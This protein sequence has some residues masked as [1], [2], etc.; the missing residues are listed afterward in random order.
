[1]TPNPDAGRPG[2]EA[3]HAPED[4]GPESG[5]LRDA[6]PPPIDARVLADASPSDASVLAGLL[7]ELSSSNPE[8]GATNVPRTTWVTLGFSSDVTA[9]L[10]TLPELSCDD[11]DTAIDVSVLDAR[12]LVVDPRGV[13]PESA[14]CVV[15]LPTVRGE[16]VVSF[17]VAATG[18]PAEVPYDRNDH[19]LLGPFPDSFY[20][21][22]DASTRTG[23]RVEVRTPD[24]DADVLQLIDAAIAPTTKLD[25]MSPIAP[26]VV[27][28]PA[29][30]DPTTIPR[31]AAES[32]SPLATL[33][34]FDVDPASP[35]HGKRVPF[36][37]L[38]RDEADRSGDPAHV[39]VVF[40]SV[41]LE[42]RGRYAFAVTNRVLVDPSRPLE[43]SSFF[44]V[45]SS[46]AAATA[47]ELRTAPGL[48]R[49]TA[50]LERTTPPLRVDDLAL[51]LAVDVRSDDD[52]P[53]DLLAI[54]Q[55]VLAAPPPAF[56]I[57]QVVA[58][59]AAGSDVAAV[60][61]GTWSPLNFTSDQ[62][63][64]AR[65]GAGRPKSVG[66]E[67]LPFTLAIPKSA[68][69][70]KAPLVMY[71]HGQPG[72]SEVEV[73]AEARRGLPGSGLALIGF[74]DYANR[75]IIPDGDVVS[76]NAQAIAALFASGDLPDY[77]SLLTHAEQL[78]FLRLL[79]TLGIID[80]L[81]LGAPDGVPDLDVNAPLGYFGISQGSIHGT[82]FL[83]FAPE[84]HAAVL[85][86]GGGRFSGTLVHQTSEA[87]YQ[88]ITDILPTL[89]RADFYAG[90]AL[91]Q[92]GYDR[93]DPLT[94]ARFFR[95]APLSLG[96]TA[97]ASV[98][99]TE[100]LGDSLVPW[101][102][103]RAGAHALGLSQLVP[104]AEAVPFLP[105]VTGP[106]SANV[107]A[108]TTGAFYQFVPAGYPLAT[109]SPGCVA[110]AETEGHFCP[111]S[112]S[113]AIAQRTTF[114]KSAVSGVPTVLHP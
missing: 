51:A 110:L 104:A 69:T 3:G 45:V 105:Q 6:S 75:V 86:V 42:P 80:V 79:P 43:A 22:E 11:V 29:A 81:P 58:D 17:G 88:G 25:G 28:L 35:N 89:T 10:A 113:E 16:R 91:V 32:L 13:L 56:T 47:D 108:D 97:R 2:A 76:L 61:T 73:P 5:T 65:D 8:A 27:A 106:V 63:F 31:T 67:T 9:D 87:L 52:L 95:R 4:G 93:Q 39:L 94:L 111:Q 18:A 55:Q 50:E 53:L 19:R 103:T 64:I 60:V 101:Y 12:T 72:S 46:G 85:T 34:L 20:T 68:K 100:G 77:L 36:D 7:P 99:M 41:P 74:T 66:T 82:G 1:G 15:R 37:A 14:T 102:S 71:Q 23:R 48:L 38:L 26:I 70:T 40:P 114:L 84:I 33:G 96:T 107:D 78:S 54:R 98:L 92:M 44:R 62:T 57:T 21:V 49:V 90:I 109:S 30:V 83:A 59:T 112:A 24:L